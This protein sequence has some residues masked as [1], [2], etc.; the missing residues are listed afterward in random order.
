MLLAIGL[1]CVATLA[2][3][4]AAAT[5]RNSRPLPR[6]LAASNERFLRGLF[7][8]G[9]TLETRYIW[10]P[11]KVAV[12]FV[13]ERVAICGSCSAPSNAELPRGRVVRIT[14]DRQTG[15]SI[16]GLEFC[17][18]RKAYPLRSYCVRR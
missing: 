13:F 10:Y 11:R 7:A 3:P 2:A 12:V 17:E 8:T 18:A 4:I 14:Y 9:R 16:G 6:W 5:H 15:R 1:V